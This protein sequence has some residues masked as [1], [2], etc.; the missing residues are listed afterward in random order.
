MQISKTDF[1][2]YL[3]CPKSLWL[4]K[5]KS[6]DY[7]HGEFSDYAK[8]LAAEGYE[9][10][11]Y[12]RQLIEAGE[13]AARFSFQTVF[14][15]DRGLYAKADMVR[16]NEDGS[17][18][19]YEIKSSTRVK[20]DAKHNQVKDACFQMIAAEEVGQN[21]RDVFIVHLNGEYVRDGEIDPQATASPIFFSNSSDAPVASRRWASSGVIDPSA[22]YAAISRRVVSRA[23]VSRIR[24]SVVSTISVTSTP[25]TAAIAITGITSPMSASVS[26]VPVMP[27]S[28]AS[29]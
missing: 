25:P 7:P 11:A 4:L 29:G 16:T 12:V 21:V 3:H 26:V 8:K 14:Q 18:N 23:R 10:E 20:T 15:T 19:L 28:P 17:V 24:R 13:D 27:S 9:V 1:I 22:T 2:Q 5:H 6:D